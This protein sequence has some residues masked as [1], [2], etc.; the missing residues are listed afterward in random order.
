MGD[1]EFSKKPRRMTSPPQNKQEMMV[2]ESGV[3][4]VMETDPARIAYFAREATWGDIMREPTDEELADTLAEVAAGKT[5]SAALK[6]G[7]GF[8]IRAS[9]VTMDQ[10]LRLAE[11]SGG[12]GSGAGAQTTRDNDMRDYN[13]IIPRTIANRLEPN[14]TDDLNGR[15]VQY[16]ANG[17]KLYGEM[18]DAGIP[19]QDARYIALP[20]G[21]Q[22]QWLHVMSLGNFV[23]MCEHRLCNGL[24]QWEI[25]YLTRCMRDAVVREYPWMD[26]ACRSSCEK[27]GCCASKT[28]LFPPCG[29]YGLA[30]DAVTDRDTLYPV[31]Q[32]SAMEFARWDI[33]RNN[34]ENETGEIYTMAGP[35]IKLV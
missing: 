9:R 34:L 33:D 26:I 19:P 35:P 11:G 2:G 10:A 25:N 32:N 23:K 6:G 22:T 27:R 28:M 14:V 1:L 29:A 21:F 5:L 15:I 31:D 18:V 7:V 30:K 20:Q 17:R 13:I 4:V 8:R 24:V 16:I 12:A 3:E